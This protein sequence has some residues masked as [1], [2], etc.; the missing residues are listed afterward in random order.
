MSKK[1]I[2]RNL[3]ARKKTQTIENKTKERRRSETTIKHKNANWKKLDATGI[4]EE[5]KRD[6]QRTRRCAQGC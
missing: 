1:S 2:R 5:D 4:E 6:Q 3:Y